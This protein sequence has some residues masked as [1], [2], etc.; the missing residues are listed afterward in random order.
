MIKWALALMTTCLVSAPPASAQDRHASY[1]YPVPKTEKTYTARARTLPES[2]RDR[3]L[4]FVVAF[5]A[6]MASEAAQ[7][8]YVQF[9]KGTDTEQLIMVALDDQALC[10]PL[11]RPRG[12]RDPDVTGT[13]FSVICRAWRPEP[14]YVL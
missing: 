3:H 6:E 1:Y 5:M 7:Q 8:Q 10:D 14:V 12:S 11:S 13:G 9:A 2:D 4:G